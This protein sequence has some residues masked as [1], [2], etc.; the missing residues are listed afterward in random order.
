MFISGSANSQRIICCQLIGLHEE[1]IP[2]YR[3]PHMF[4]SRRGGIVTR[5]AGRQN[6]RLARHVRAGW[7]ASR[8]VIL[9]SRAGKPADTPKA[10]FI[11]RSA[12]CACWI[13]MPFDVM[14]LLLVMAGELLIFASDSGV[15][16]SKRRRRIKGSCRRSNSPTKPP[17][18]ILTKR[19]C[20]DKHLPYS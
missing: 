14:F 12:P 8:L 2:A 20:T 11:S 9:Y 6:L 3:R 17:K 13:I 10:I 5:N 16:V 1:A 7:D 4:F 18:T 19:E 15:L